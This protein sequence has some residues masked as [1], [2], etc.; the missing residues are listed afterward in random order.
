MSSSIGLRNVSPLFILGDEAE[1]H[2]Q[3]FHHNQTGGT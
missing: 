3:M 2:R 1:H